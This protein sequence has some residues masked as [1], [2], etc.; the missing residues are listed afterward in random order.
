[1]TV[2]DWIAEPTN[3][4]YLVLALVIAVSALRVVTSTNVVHAAL[5]LVLALAGTAGLFLLLSAEFV[6]WVLVLVYIGAVIVLFLFGIMITRAPTGPN[7]E[8]DHQRRAPAAMAAFLIF[9]VTAGSALTAFGDKQ[10][11]NLGRGTSTEVIGE[12]LLQ[13]FVI[14]FEVVS[15]VLLAALIGGITLARKDATPAEEMAREGSDA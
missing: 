6:A 5:F 8:V 11:S 14:P 15:F 12:Q 13:R 9:I 2:A 7:V 1:M 4:V 10:I 3:W